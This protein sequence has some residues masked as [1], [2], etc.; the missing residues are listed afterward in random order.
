MNRGGKI[1]NNFNN[2]P[3]NRYEHDLSNG[4]NM[5][6]VLVGIFE[7]ENDA[8]SAIRRLKNS[9]YQEDEITVVAKDREKM[10][11]IADMTDA[12]TKTQDGDGE[13]GTGVVI[14]AGIG[15]LAAAMPALGLI[16][17]PGIGPLLAAGPIALIIGGIIT[18]GLAGGLVGA[19]VKMG[20]NEEDAKEYDGYINIGKI[21]VM[22][23]NKNNLSE[24]VYR[25]YRE[26]NSIISN[27]NS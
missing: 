24:D 19:L 17:I 1:M 25:A 10:E 8:I 15:G 12:D 21:L 20:V 14:G 6:K 3:M 16:L 4:S 5:D 13:I 7:T 18:G 23:N 26:N 2:D 22:V 9:G 11:N 27:R